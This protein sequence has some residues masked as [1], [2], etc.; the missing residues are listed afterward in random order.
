MISE[1]FGAQLLNKRAF[2]MQH[3]EYVLVKTN[4]MCPGVLL[5]RPIEVL[6]SEAI[7]LFNT[8]YRDRNHHRLVL[9]P[10]TLLY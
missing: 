1:T 10:P 7:E 2:V 3:S 5:Q 9:D 8:T 6:V 4:E